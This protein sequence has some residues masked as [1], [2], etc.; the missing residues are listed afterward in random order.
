MLLEESW[1]AKLKNKQW[2]VTITRRNLGFHSPLHA[3]GATIT[4]L[5]HL[6]NIFMLLEVLNSESIV[7]VEAQT[8]LL[9]L[10]RSL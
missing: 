10:T 7:I 8:S 9:Y 6:M 2:S 5:F 3:R 4:V 1:E